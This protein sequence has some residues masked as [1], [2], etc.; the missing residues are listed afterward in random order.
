M[1]VITDYFWS[2]L[3]LLPKVFFICNNM[4]LLFVEQI[5]NKLFVI[6]HMGILWALRRNFSHSHVTNFPIQINTFLINHCKLIRQGL[7]VINFA[8]ITR[9]SYYSYVSFCNSFKETPGNSLEVCA[10]PHYMLSLLFLK[11]NS[12]TLWLN[13]II[14]LHRDF[15]LK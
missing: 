13:M 5:F 11:I 9:L 3:L 2:Y 7:S 6:G 15:D 1:F 10:E 12:H 14:Y 4:W 8:V